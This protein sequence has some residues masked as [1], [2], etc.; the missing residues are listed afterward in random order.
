VVKAGVDG[1]K[2]DGNHVI[3]PDNKERAIKVGAAI[4]QIQFIFIPFT[5]ETR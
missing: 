3:Q 1:K 4:S 2:V 5:A